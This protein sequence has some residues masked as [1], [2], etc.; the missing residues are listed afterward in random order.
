MAA[1]TATEGSMGSS[2]GGAT[3]SSASGS[4]SANATVAAIEVLS[5]GASATGTET[6]AVG[7]S[8]AGATGSSGSENAYRVTLRMDDGSTQVVT[9]QSVPDFRS[10]DRVNLSGG[11]IQH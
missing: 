11:S 5:G 9:Q 10:G 7:S 6:G 4:T 8:G 2:S 3:A 1:G